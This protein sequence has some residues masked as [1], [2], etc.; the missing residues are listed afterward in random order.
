MFCIIIGEEGWEPIDTHKIQL[1]IKQI[2]PQH[3]FED[4]VEKHAL[5]Q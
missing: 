3:C 5:I 4:L 2:V 1:H